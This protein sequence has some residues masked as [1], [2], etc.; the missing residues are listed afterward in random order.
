MSRS[1]QSFCRLIPH[2]P[3]PATWTTPK[4]SHSQTSSGTPSD[5]W[6]SSL[7]LTCLG[8]CPWEVIAM[9]T[10]LLLIIATSIACEAG[11][12]DATSW[13]LSSEARPPC[14]VDAADEE[15]PCMN[16]QHERGRMLLIWRVPNSKKNAPKYSPLPAIGEIVTLEPLRRFSKGFKNCFQRMRQRTDF[17]K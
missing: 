1:F 5:Y 2:S 3:S 16:C 12:L 11:A 6:H 8:V 14:W 7:S 13:M 15:I 10:E 17:R 4:S 9:A